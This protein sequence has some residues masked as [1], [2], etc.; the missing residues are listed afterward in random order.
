MYA[1]HVCAIALLLASVLA[2]HIIVLN[3][4]TNTSTCPAIS[5]TIIHTK[6]TKTIMQVASLGA[7][8]LVVMNL[9]QKHDKQSAFF[10][11]VF[12]LW[13]LIMFFPRNP[14]N[15]EV[16]V[17]RQ[18]LAGIMHNLCVLALFVAW[19]IGILAWMETWNTFNTFLVVVCLMT[20]AVLVVFSL[21]ENSCEVYE[22]HHHLIGLMEFV[23]IASLLWLMI[24][25]NSH[26]IALK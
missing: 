10:V 14:S 2:S 3:T 24:E 8:L 5:N 16:R 22:K 23:L 9:F 21:F 19:I 7:L 1:L 15:T 6:E 18:K 25:A 17:R 26:Q 11:G 13:C 12:V 20:F 4:H